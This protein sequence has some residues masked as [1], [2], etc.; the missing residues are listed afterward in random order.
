MHIY[1]WGWGSAEGE[2]NLFLKKYFIYLYMRDTE[3]E[4]QRHRHRE[5]Q[6]PCGEPD[7]EVDPGTPESRPEP[8]AGAQP[9][10]HPHIPT[11]S[12]SEKYF[13]VITTAHIHIPTVQL[14][15]LQTQ[16]KTTHDTRALY[17]EAY[18]SLSGSLLVTITYF[19]KLLHKK[20]SY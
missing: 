3:I 15:Y 12:T 18:K 11:S 5:K 13:Q 6:A 1:E 14:K 4:R 2:N 7:A 19:F 9:L 8:K 10:S 17:S 20:L 16:P